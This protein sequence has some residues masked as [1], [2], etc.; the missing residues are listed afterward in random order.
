[1]AGWEVAFFPAYA[2]SEGASATARAR[3]SAY[4]FVFKRI[5]LQ[6]ESVY[7]KAGVHSSFH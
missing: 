5:L 1:L 4:C 3:M 2:Q 6:S 7:K